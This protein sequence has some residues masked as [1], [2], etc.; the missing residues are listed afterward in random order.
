MNDNSQDVV[1]KN[2]KIKA[3]V[4]NAARKWL[5]RFKG[6]KGIAFAAIINENYSV[7][8]AERG[9]QGYTPTGVVLPTL[10]YHEAK[11]IVDELNADVLELDAEEAMLIVIETMRR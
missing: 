7:G 4:Y 1:P 11:D 10:N 9:T 5:V 8:I 6:T 3:D 2:K